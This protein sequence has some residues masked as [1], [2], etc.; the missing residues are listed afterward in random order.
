MNRANIIIG[1]SIILFVLSF[2]L[3][4]RADEFNFFE[5]LQYFDLGYVYSTVIVIL[6]FILSIFLFAF[7]NHKMA[8]NLALALIFM[9]TSVFGDILRKFS[10]FNWIFVKSGLETLLLYTIISLVVI[11]P[12]RKALKLNSWLWF[13]VFLFLTIALYVWL[14]D[15]NCMIEFDNDV[16]I[17]I[18]DIKSWYANC[19]KYYALWLA[20]LILIAGIFQKLVPFRN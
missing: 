14:N 3:P 7:K 2:F 19:A 20:P 13:S 16:G 1:F 18:W 15:Y 5:T 6:L 17:Q 12:L 10:K 4:H 8:F 11:F 9:N